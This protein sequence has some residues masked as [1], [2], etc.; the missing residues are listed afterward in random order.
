M[1]RFIVIAAL[2]AAVVLALPG[3]AHAWSWP[4]DGAVLRPFALGTNVYAGGQ[5]RGIDLAAPAGSAVR[6]P[7]AGIVTFQGTV[8]TH[9]RIVSILTPDG[10]SVTL[11]HLGETIVSRGET[12]EEGQQVGTVGPSGTPEHETP[13]VHFGVRVAAEAQGYVDPAT[14]LPGRAAP[15]AA[16][17]SETAAA[18]ES[19]A[20]TEGTG[21]PSVGASTAAA[22]EPHSEAAPP[23][24]TLAAPVPADPSPAM[25]PTLSAPP[26]GAAPTPEESSVAVSAAAVALAAMPA[27]AEHVPVA[28]QEPAPIPPSVAGADPAPSIASVAA[29]VPVPGSVAAA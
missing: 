20:A 23:N 17:T 26:P 15:S 22:S 29:A 7:A 19:T 11:T 2:A 12:V 13:Y 21:T 16:P 4:T 9:G 6:A 3:G 27:P 24:D 28:A 14:F 8:P 25:A 10:Y 1:R 18:A 5:H